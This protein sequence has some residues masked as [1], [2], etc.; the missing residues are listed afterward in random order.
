[1]YVISKDMYCC[2]YG[3]SFGFNV[4]CIV[5]AKM[6]VICKTYAYIVYEVH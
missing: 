1:M 4:S 2:R 5:L 6:S 3:K